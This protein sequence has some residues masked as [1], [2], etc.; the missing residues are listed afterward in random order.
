MG[1]T[2]EGIKDVHIVTHPIILNLINFKS[3]KTQNETDFLKIC[4]SNLSDSQQYHLNL[5]LSN[6]EPQ[7]V[8]QGYIHQFGL[9]KEYRVT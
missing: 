2:V 9:N 3:L 4:L 5:Y 6:D 7:L 8:I 1:S